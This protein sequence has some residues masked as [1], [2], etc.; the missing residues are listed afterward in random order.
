MVPDLQDEF[1]VLCYE[2]HGLTDVNSSDCSMFCLNLGTLNKYEEI[3][4]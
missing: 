3:Y 4:Y 2:M 1:N